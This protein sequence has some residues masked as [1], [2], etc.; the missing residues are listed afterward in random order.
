[1]PAGEAPAAAGARAGVP[2]ARIRLHSALRSH[3]MPRTVSRFSC[4]NIALT[5]LLLC[6]CATAFKRPRFKKV[7]MKR[8]KKAKKE[9]AEAEQLM[10]GRMAVAGGGQ[11]PALATLPLHIG[12]AAAPAPWPAPADTT[13]CKVQ[14]SSWRWR[15]MKC[16]VARTC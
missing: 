6:V 14:K 10:Q 4:P 1:M 16:R 11:V 9:V 2:P 15:K 7:G 13:S 8:A 5:L 3:V 12:V